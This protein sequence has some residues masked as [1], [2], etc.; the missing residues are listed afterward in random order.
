MNKTLF[1]IAHC[2]N[3]LSH[4][5]KLQ[6]KQ[7]SSKLIFRQLQLHPIPTT[8]TCLCRRPRP[9]HRSRLR[10]IILVQPGHHLIGGTSSVHI[11]ITTST[12]ISPIPCLQNILTYVTIFLINV[13]PPPRYHGDAVVK[14]K[15]MFMVSVSDRDWQES[16]AHM[17][18]KLA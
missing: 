8:S 14:T 10:R 12:T 1:N 7:H 15:F 18:V 16:A 9:L 4:H 3:A 5:L 6:L 13:T 17:K 11:K 2:S